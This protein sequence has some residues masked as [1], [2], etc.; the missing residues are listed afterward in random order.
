MPL[1]ANAKKFDPKAQKTFRTKTSKDPITGQTVTQ[2]IA[3]PAPGK[4]FIWQDGDIYEVDAADIV[5]LPTT[6]GP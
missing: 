2:E 4:A 6:Q 5:P 1:P 3:V